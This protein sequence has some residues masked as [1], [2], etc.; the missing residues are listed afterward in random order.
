MKAGDGGNGAVSFRREK[1]VP[2]G[3]PDG[4]DGGRGG[5]CYV[6]ADAGMSTLYGLWRKRHFRAGRGAHGGGNRM[7]G[8]SG[9]DCIVRVP[10]GTV[11]SAR[12][13]GELQALADLEGDGQEA[14]VARGGRGGRGNARFAT[15][16]NQAPRIAERGEAGEEVTLQLDLKLIADVGIVGKPSVG[17]STLLAAA[18]AARPRVADYPFTT[19]EPVLGVVGV[20]N[21]AFVLAEI[22][23]LIEGAHLGHGLGHDFLRHAERTKVLIH[24]LDGSSPSLLD[25]MRDINRELE[26]YSPL[27]AG[28]AQIAVVNKIDI[29]QVRERVPALERELAS[30]QV[31]VF[32]ISAATGEGVPGLMARAFQTART[33]AEQSAGGEG[34]AVFKPRPRRER[35][36]VTR[37]G[38]L[39]VVSAAAVEGLIA[40]MDLDNPEA[41]AYIWGELERRGVA[42][43]LKRAGAAPGARVRIASWETEWR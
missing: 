23:G 14:L 13:D 7:H 18:S 11:V 40:R 9:E 3:G 10:V 5:S 16:T 6:V 43:A 15:S 35:L 21:H 28:K 30:D 20:G 42:A 24:L 36:A 32:F 31:P 26:L 39:F 29:P 38:D 27:L 8:R 34:P 1:F 37:E 12:R 4:G 2:F 25:D 33:I 41:R 22:P 19:T 17:K